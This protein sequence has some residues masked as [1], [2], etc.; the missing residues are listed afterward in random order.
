MMG[1]TRFNEDLKN[2]NNLVIPVFFVEIILER[3][4]PGMEMSLKVVFIVLPVVQNCA[5]IVL[6]LFGVFYVALAVFKLLNV[7]QRSFA[8][9]KIVNGINCDESMN[10]IKSF[11]Q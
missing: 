8:P 7:K 6:A 11:E 2:F 3:L 5:I 4:T 9:E 10:F 1:E